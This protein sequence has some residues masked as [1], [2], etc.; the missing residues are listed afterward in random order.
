[1]LGKIDHV[2]IIVKDFDESLKFYNEILGFPIIQ[3]WETLNSK[4]EP[5]VGLKV[6]YV[7]KE[8]SKIE[9]MKFYQE[10][11]P[12]VEKRIGLTHISILVDDIEGKC[13]E[14]ERKGINLTMKPISIS[15]ELKIAFF[16]DPNGVYIEL[17][18][19]S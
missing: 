3:I 15:E 6:A 1:M 10:R 7:G 4:E 16:K 17:I 12:D 5:G 13:K 2:A 19:K 18:E 8:G 11:E 9:L 14:L